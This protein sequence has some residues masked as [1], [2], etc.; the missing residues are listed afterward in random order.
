MPLGGRNVACDVAAALIYW[1]LAKIAKLAEK[2]GADV[3]NFP[4]TDFRNATFA[5][6]RSNSRDR[7]GTPLEQRFT[8]AEMEEML[9]AAG[10]YEVKFREGFPYWCAVGIKGE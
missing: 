10:V 4:L 9:N 2:L 1:P 8:K 7:L 3:E 5:R 6:M